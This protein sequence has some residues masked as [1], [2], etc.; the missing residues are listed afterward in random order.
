M[1]SNTLQ[2]LIL[3]SLGYLMTASIGAALAITMDLPARFGGILNGTDVPRDFLI[4]NGTAL[5][6]DL[7]MLLGQLALTLCAPR[8]GR[9]G[10]VGVVGLTVLG[11]CYVAGQLGEPILLQTFTPARFNAA[12]AALVAANIAFSSLMVVFG[13]L[14]WRNR[15]DDPHG[16]SRGLLDSARPKPETV[17]PVSKC[18]GSRYS[19][20]LT[21]A[22][23]RGRV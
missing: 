15:G 6:P 18:S 14:A 19:H 13:M 16:S 7:A 22:R 12:Q 10:M 4:I 9:V 5:S 23:N 1:R 17:A 20:A 2:W 11:V 3:S 8:R 21:P